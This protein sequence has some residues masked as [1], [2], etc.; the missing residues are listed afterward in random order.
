MS[1]LFCLTE[2]QMARLRPA[3]P[4]GR[5][6]PR[7]D[8]RQVVVGIIFIRRNGLRWCDTPRK[9]GPPKPLYSRR[10]GQGT[11]GA[12]ARMMDRLRPDSLVGTYAYANPTVAPLA[13]R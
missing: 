5:D 1:Q 10:K 11:I 9:Y 2:K 12:S 7:G 3:F 6:R 4:I 8:D 13:A